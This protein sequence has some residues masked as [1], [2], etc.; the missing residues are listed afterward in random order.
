MKYLELTLVDPAHNLACD[1]ALLD[2]FVAEG[3]DDGLLRLWQ[4]ASYFVVLGHSNRLRAEVNVQECAAAGVPILRRIS[5]GGAVLQGPGC[6]NYSLILDVKTHDVKNIQ[7]GFRYV[8]E[9]HRRLLRELILGD[10]QIDGISDLT[11]AGR[12]ISGNAQYRKT[13]HVLVH[14]T[15]LSAM[16][17]SMIDRCL[18]LPKKQPAYRDNRPHLEF[19]A[20]LNLEN[21]RICSALRQ[22][23]SATE[24]LSPPLERVGQL[25]DSRYGR[26]DWSAKF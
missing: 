8:L 23:W 4:P 5:G 22:S 13:R 26:P 20:N 17:L 19:V 15:F 2:W 3:V 6:L 9:R 18:L 1:E 21:A 7:A 16:D 10:V 25:V 12:K 14:G 11:V 24:S